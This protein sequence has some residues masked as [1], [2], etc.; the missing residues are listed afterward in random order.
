MTVDQL[1]VRTEKSRSL[2]WYSRR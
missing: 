2:T 1:N